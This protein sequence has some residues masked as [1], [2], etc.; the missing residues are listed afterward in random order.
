MSD[1]IQPM[2][3]EDL[4]DIEDHARTYKEA[5]WDNTL[6]LIAEI[7]R[8]KRGD[9]TE[10]EFQ[11][12]CH[13]LEPDDLKRFRQG[14]EDYQ[15]KLFGYKKPKDEEERQRLRAHYGEKM[16]S[17]CEC[18]KDYLRAD[19]VI[20]GQIFCPKCRIERGCAEIPLRSDPAVLCKGVKV[21]L[22]TDDRCKCTCADTCPLGRKGSELR[23]TKQEL[24]AGN[25]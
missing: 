6:K 12:L 8:L 9:F 25:G 14:C 21:T 15:S 23:C 16:E 7:K 2:S 10:E 13:S 5:H 4:R 17:C 11:N 20:D 24:E 22:G 1:K 19:L 18:G 3:K